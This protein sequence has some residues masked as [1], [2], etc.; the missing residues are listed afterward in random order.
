M[1]VVIAIK[2]KNSIVMGCDGLV[3]KG[4]LKY[5]TPS[6]IFKIKNCDRGLLGSAGLLRG[7]QILEVQHNLIDEI[8]QLKNEVNFEYCVTTLYERIYKLFTQYRLVDK[9]NGEFVRYLPNSF[10]L[11]YKD[12]A[13]RIEEDGCVDE[14]DDFLVIGSGEETAQAVLLKNK[15]K[16]AEDR[17]KEAIEA[18]AE[19][20]LYVND[21]I[22]IMRT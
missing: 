6:K 19:K 11:A 22:T 17:I 8:T 13:F 14:I 10:I 21:N 16:K 18:C 15:G 5:K 1:S 20:T 7:M 9:E 3:V 12:N 2:E 4:H